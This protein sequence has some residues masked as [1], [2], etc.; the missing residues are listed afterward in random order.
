MVRLYM[1]RIP[2][3]A[4]LCEITEQL[5]CF[6]PF[7]FRGCHLSC[8]DLVNVCRRNYFQE[9]FL[10]CVNCLRK[11]V[12]VLW[13]GLGSPSGTRDSALDKC[14]IWEKPFKWLFAPA[15]KG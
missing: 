14:I 7:P 11:S 2:R 13:G 10:K 15:G 9:V 1:Y 8:K 12:H 3:C 4:V 6:L 5:L